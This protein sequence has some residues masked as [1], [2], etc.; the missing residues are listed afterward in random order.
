[1]RV[2]G[3]DPGIGRT[4]V[5]VVDG[6]IGQLVLHHS[7]CVTTTPGTADALRLADM[8]RQLTAV[9][10]LYQPDSAAV[11][12]LYFSSNRTTAMQVAQARGVILCVLAQAGVSI[13]E[14]APN[15]VKEAVAGYGAARKPQV[16]RMVRRLLSAEKLDGPDDVADACAVAICHHHRNGFGSA[17]ALT[18]TVVAP[19]LARAIA[20][21]QATSG[22]R[23]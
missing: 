12:T 20:A 5:A 17:M 16:A 18:G 11:E 13:A 2:L 3:I 15:Q 4:G 23:R 22:A 7:S 14:Y 1:M 10:E 21:A 6:G 8:S 19:S 9:L